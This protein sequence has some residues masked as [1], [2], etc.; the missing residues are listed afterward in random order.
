MSARPRCPGALTA[1]AL[2][3]AAL[4]AAAAALAALASALAAAP[5]A[6]LAAAPAAAQPTRHRREPDCVRLGGCGLLRRAGENIGGEGALR[7]A[8]GD[9]GLRREG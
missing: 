4:A 9:D 7:G 1:A 5:A 6:A 3:A 2:A 8:S